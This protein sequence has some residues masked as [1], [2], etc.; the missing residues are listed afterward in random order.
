MKKLFLF[1]MDG[2]LTLARKKMSHD[3][4]ANLTNLQKNGWDIGIISGSDMDY[5]E[6]QCDIMF[7]I[8]PL[9]P[10]TVHFLPCNGTKYFKNFKK[11]WEYCMQS[12][13][14]DDV[15]KDLMKDL[16]FAQQC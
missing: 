4:L 8:S 6:Q 12:E 5:I 16:I 7:D 9:N 1:D 2:T 10:R 3:M 11:V 14:G 15:M 13:I